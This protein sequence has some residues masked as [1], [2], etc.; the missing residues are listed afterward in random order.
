MLAIRGGCCR[1]NRAILFA[2][3]R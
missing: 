1:K 3:K 2:R